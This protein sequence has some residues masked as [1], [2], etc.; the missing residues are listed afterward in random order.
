M[1]KHLFPFTDPVEAQSKPPRAMQSGDGAYVTDE[2]GNTFLDAV[3][4]LWCASLGFNPKRLQDA[5]ARQLG[6][7]GYYHSF[8]G[9][10]CSVTNTLADRL[11]EKLPDGLDHV[12]F[13]TS[14]SEAVEN[15]IKFA[16]FFQ[17]GRGKPRKSRVI[18]RTGAY[19]G[20]LN[21]SAALTGMSY[22]HD[23]FDVPL[24]DVIRTG[25]TH[26]FRDAHEGESEAQFGQRRVAELEALIE[27]EGADT[28]CAF[29]G[30]PL[31]GSGGVF[32]PPPGYWDGV[33]KVLRKHDIL[34]IA[35]EII[36][37]FGRTG[38]WFGS[39]TFGIKPDLM[40][41]AKQLTAAMFPMSAVA[42][43]DAV[44]NGIAD[45]AHQLGTFGHGVTYG[46]HP[47]G[48]AIALETLDIY[49][50]MDLPNHV[51]RLGTY[52]ENRLQPLKQSPHVG[53]IRT[54]GLVAGIEFGNGKSPSS[55]LAKRVAD[56]AENHGVLFRLI[57]DTLAISP[58]YICDEGD[59]D[60]M[61]DVLAGG[62]SSL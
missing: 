28:I 41:M 38:Q 30:E 8:M 53:E 3:S 36:T 5:A 9:R 15:A 18:A 35:D 61:V 22:C 1:T 48:A 13:G 56:Y 39:Q 40:T 55:G 27:A 37:G 12:F 2:H 49:D 21:I 25:G 47:V 11:V 24:S 60:K 62:L 59:I 4:G 19:H 23:G 7:L 17:I 42:M 52:L 14:G 51:Q 43:T 54:V 45:H 10:T 31:M 33:Q 29:I 44:Y 6:T 32:L 46:G 20:S 57:N 34:L 50:E 26:Y 16:R 58:P